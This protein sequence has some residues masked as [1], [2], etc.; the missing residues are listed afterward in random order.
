M[1][2]R[3]EKKQR[4]DDKLKRKNRHVARSN[5][6]ERPKRCV[7]FKKEAKHHGL[8]LR[9]PL[10]LQLTHHSPKSRDSKERRKL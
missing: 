9:A 8:K 6:V 10:L 5:D 4:C 7:S 2:I 3:V 1:F